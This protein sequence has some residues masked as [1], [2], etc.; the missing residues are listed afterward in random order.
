M[1]LDSIFQY[2]NHSI[3]MSNTTYSDIF[4]ATCFTNFMIAACVR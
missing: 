4:V 2:G 1:S 3:P